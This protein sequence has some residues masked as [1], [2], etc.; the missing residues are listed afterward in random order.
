MT[1]D[2]EL[3][4]IELELGRGT[5]GLVDVNLLPEWNMLM[6]R[7]RRH[8]SGCLHV[9]PPTNSVCCRCPSGVAFIPINEI[10][11]FNIWKGSRRDL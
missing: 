8:C 11:A 4:D 3:K 1:I 7:D 10:P 9:I 6:N 2:E 5:H